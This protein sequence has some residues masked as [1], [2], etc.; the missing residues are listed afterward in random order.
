MSLNN[1]IL[2]LAIAIPY[3]SSPGPAV[4]LA[5]NYSIN[6][7]IKNTLNL[8]LGN[9]TGLGIL[10]FVSA[11]G[12]GF[13]ITASPILKTIMQMGGAI[14]LVYLGFKMI[15][16]TQTK[17]TLKNS[18]KKST[19]YKEGILL[20]ITNPKPIIFFSSI[21]PQFVDSN[22]KTVFLDFSIL[23]IL[24]MLSSF[25]ILLIYSLFSKRFFNLFL[26]NPKHLKRF[27]IISGSILVLLGIILVF[28]SI[29]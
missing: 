19:F 14:F 29:K 1:I 26:N 18:K 12:V 13:I 2:F 7:G 15:N 27:N 21:Y 10:A 25:F 24:F 8:L 5:I 11:I 22:S 4:F 6:Y 3:I 20:A 16:T 28:S 9:T 23:G 17:I